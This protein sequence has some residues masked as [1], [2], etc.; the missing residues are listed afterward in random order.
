V[1]GTKVYGRLS[2]MA[3]WL[4]EVHPV[5]DLPPTA[6]VPPPKITSTVVHFRPK[7][8]PDSDPPFSLVEE[9]TA[10]AF[11]QRRKMIR[12]SL[13]KYAAAFDAAGLEETSRAEE[14]SV[15]DYLRLCRVIQAS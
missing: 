7:T 3:Q 15:A 5:F 1:S 14:L 12:S 8:I 13:K 6:F 11:Q 4:C 2:I 10:L 9:V